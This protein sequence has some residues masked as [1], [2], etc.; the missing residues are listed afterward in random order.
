MCVHVGWTQKESSDSNSN[1]NSNIERH[2]VFYCGNKLLLFTA[3]KF[4]STNTYSICVWCVLCC[5]RARA[6]FIS[7]FIHL[8]IHIVYVCVSNAIRLSFISLSFHHTVSFTFFMCVAY[9][10][11]IA[12]WWY[13][14]LL[15]VYAQYIW[16]KDR[17]K[18]L[19]MALTT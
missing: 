11:L 10:F 14:V 4:Y 5:E 18:A 8:Y 16:I 17:F 13:Q 2:T 7:L 15:F 1:S 3:A 6:F 9:F 12:R 19:N